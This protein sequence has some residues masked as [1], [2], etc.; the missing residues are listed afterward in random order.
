MWNRPL[1]APAPARPAPAKKPAKP[2]NANRKNSRVRVRVAKSREHVTQKV[3]NHLPNLGI[4]H[5]YAHEAAT[6]ACEGQF[7]R[8]GMTAED[9]LRG[10]RGTREGEALLDHFRDLSRRYH[11]RVVT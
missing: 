9:V 11:L 3:A 8:D 6:H 7:W 1:Y 10:L 5:A 4:S 2:G